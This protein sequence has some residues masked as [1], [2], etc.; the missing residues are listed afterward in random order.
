MKSK[1]SLGLFSVCVV[2]MCEIVKEQ[3][4]L[5]NNKSNVLKKNGDK[6]RE[7]RIMCL[8]EVT[9]GLNMTYIMFIPLALGL[10]TEC[11]REREHESREP[12][13]GYC[14]PPEEAKEPGTTTLMIGQNLAVYCHVLLLTEHQCLR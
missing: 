13:G 6:W 12:S 9:I 2:Y 4:C 10:K 3:V 14:R 5:I 7:H 1:N 8:D 11:E